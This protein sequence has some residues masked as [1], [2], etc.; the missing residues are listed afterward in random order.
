ME[1][2]FP[3]PF[4]LLHSSVKDLRTP[5]KKLSSNRLGACF[6]RRPGTFFDIL[7]ARSGQTL[8]SSRSSD[9]VG[10]L[11]AAAGRRD[12]GSASQCTVAA[13]KNTAAARC[14]RRMLPEAPRSGSKATAAFAVKK[15]VYL[16]QAKS[17][18]VVCM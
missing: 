5:S 11:R 12:D 7:H 4:L 18:D 3:Q 9:V 13:V 17:A 16:R 14:R 2:P 8:A 10:A 15:G 1:F 6:R